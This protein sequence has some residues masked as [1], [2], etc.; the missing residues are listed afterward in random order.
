[1][2]NEAPIL[3]SSRGQA[4]VTFVSNSNIDGRNSTRIR[5]IWRTQVTGGL[6]R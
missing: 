6:S 1:M 2:T 5:R 4:T 3:T